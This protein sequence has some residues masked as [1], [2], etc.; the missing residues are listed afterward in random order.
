MSFEYMYEYIRLSVLL[1]A[2]FSVTLAEVLAWAFGYVYLL[3]EKLCNW[4]VINVVFILN[5][6]TWLNY[7]FSFYTLL[8]PVLY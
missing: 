4:A 1:E 5:Y 7:L 6:V 8:F 2:Y 3:N